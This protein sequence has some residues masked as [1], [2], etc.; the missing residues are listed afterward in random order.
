MNCLSDCNRER[1]L[2]SISSPL[3]NR[4]TSLH[5]SRK[6]HPTTS[7]RCSSGPHRFCSSSHYHYCFPIQFLLSS[8]LVRC[9]PSGAH[10]RRIRRCGPHWAT[11]LLRDACKFNRNSQLKGILKRPEKLTHCETTQQRTLVH[12]SELALQWLHSRRQC[13]PLS[14]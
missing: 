11:K 2:L 14:T 8:L 7:F 1:I 4:L 12:A 9:P 13:Y 6:P 10:C 5:C 3:E